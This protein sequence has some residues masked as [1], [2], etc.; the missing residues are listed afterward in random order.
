MPELT[1]DFVAHIADTLFSLPGVVSVTLGGS[2]ALGTAT[3]TSDWDFAIYYRGTFD[4]DDLRALGWEGQVFDIGAWGGGVFNGGAWVT[5]QGRKVDVLYRDLDAI[6]HELAEAA[7]GRFHWESL[8]FNLAGIPSY[9]ILAE[10][11][12]NRHLRGVRLP[13]PEFPQ[14]LRASAARVWRDNAE[15][16]LALSAKSYADR[17]QFAETAAALVTAA[18]QTAHAVLAARGEWVTNEK[19]L[20]A[21]AGLRD[22]DRIIAVAGTDPEALMRSV[23]EARALFASAG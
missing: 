18:L 4:P 12:L 3:P 19:R 14:L 20:L 17:G 6:D 9:L 23:D 10:L 8:M 15:L 7:E 13:Q 2:Q 1:T 22:V 16:T 5:V 21:R 11:A